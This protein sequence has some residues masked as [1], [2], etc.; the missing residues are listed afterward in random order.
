MTFALFVVLAATIW[1]GHAMQSERDT[2]V[3]VMVSYTGVPETIGFAGDGL[4]DTVM[5][6]V[7]DAGKQLNVYKR[8]PLHLTIRADG[9]NLARQLAAQNVEWEYADSTCI[10]LLLSPVM[11]EDDFRRLEKAL[12]AC[13]PHAAA[14][15]PAL[16]EPPEKAVSMREAAISAWEPI[17]LSD[18]VGCICG[19][20]LWR[21]AG[22][23]V[24]VIILINWGLKSIEPFIKKL[25]GKGD[26]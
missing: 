20:G 23:A 13:E 22:I 12:S 5:I 7:R 9:N 8:D 19:Y 24:C 1:F 2:R 18:A 10:V 11:T 4:P 3:P 6:E 21:E 15:P 17:P 25:F 26:E 16:P 14:V